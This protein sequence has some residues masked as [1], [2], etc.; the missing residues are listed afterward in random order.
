MSDPIQSEFLWPPR[1]LTDPTPPAVSPPLTPPPRTRRNAVAR[2][3]IDIERIWLDPVAEP[4]DRRAGRLNWRRA[5]PGDWCDRCG[6]N[7]GPNEA[8][9]LG[10]AQCRGRRLPWDRFVRLGDYEPPLSTWVQE[11]KFGGWRALGRSLGRE[12]G[13]AALEAGFE[14][15]GGA[16]VPAPTTF[17]RRMARGIDHALVLARGVSCE[18][19]AP[20]RRL[21]QRTHRPSQRGLSPAQRTSNVAGSFSVRRGAPTGGPIILIDDVMTTGATLRAASRVL[22]RGVRPSELWVCVTSVARPLDG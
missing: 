18:T 16:V 7:V 17:R 9:E 10:C 1:P 3:W 11:V 21:L 2:A 8:D 19:G 22:R 13:R 14:G 6:A 5:S 15:A 12:L 4:L 20:V